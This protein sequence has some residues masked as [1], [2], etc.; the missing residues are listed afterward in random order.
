MGYIV[1]KGLA[2][3]NN[4]INNQSYFYLIQHGYILDNISLNERVKTPELTF[5]GTC[6]GM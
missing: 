3:L 2:T 6:R 5:L 4:K 1:N